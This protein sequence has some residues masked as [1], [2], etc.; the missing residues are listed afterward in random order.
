MENCQSCKIEP[1][2]I[3]DLQDSEVEPYRLCKDCHQRF[4]SRSLRPREYFNL[5]TK[6][7]ITYLL[8]DNFYNEN[9]QCHHLEANVCNSP[10]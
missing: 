7:G 1:A 6:H 3:M 9:G 10:K 8:S 2:E 5:R 4:I